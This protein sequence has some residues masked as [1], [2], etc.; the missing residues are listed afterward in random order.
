[1]PFNVSN[2][3]SKVYK[4][5]IWVSV[6]SNINAERIYVHTGSQKTDYFTQIQVLFTIIICSFLTIVKK[7]APKRDF[8][9]MMKDH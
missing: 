6:S 4:H 7:T 9:N 2:C 1:M 3:E 8:L 5:G